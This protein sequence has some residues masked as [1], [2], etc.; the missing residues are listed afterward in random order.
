[1]GL[2]AQGSRFL[3]RKI[4]GTMPSSIHLKSAGAWLTWTLVLGLFPIWTSA[5]VYAMARR[6]EL[7]SSLFD[8]GQLALY[9]AGLIATA[10]YLASMDREP[11][12]MRLRSSL[13]LASFV[14]ILAAVTIHVGVQTLGIL[15]D[16]PRLSPWFVVPFSAAT[17][18]FAVLV[19]TIASAVDAERI[20]D[21]VPAER[22]RQIDDLS[23]QM[24]NLP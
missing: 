16:G 7:I 18:V 22:G 1:M 9:A 4:M 19:A 10:S 24:E 13:L 6:P 17:L 2:I 15:T 23:E 5:M 21:Q 3:W 12:G 14:V 20:M 11:A 8:Q